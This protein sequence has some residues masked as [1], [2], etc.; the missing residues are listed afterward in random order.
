MRATLALNGLKKRMMLIM[1]RITIEWNYNKVKNGIIFFSLIVLQN[2]EKYFSEILT[3]NGI[4]IPHV[5]QKCME[6]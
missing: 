6:Y 4:I 1:N 5:K 3:R 2:F